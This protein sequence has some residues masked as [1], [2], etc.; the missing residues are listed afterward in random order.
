VRFKDHSA[1]E[2]L[3]SAVGLSPF[4]RQLYLTA[5]SGQANSL[6]RIGSD[7]KVVEDLS[8]RFGE[9]VWLQIGGEVIAVEVFR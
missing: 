2:G 1:V 7:G 6:V 5:K 3:L 8:A 4:D 9:G